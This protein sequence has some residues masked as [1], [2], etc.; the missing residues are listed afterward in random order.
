MGQLIK[1][2]IGQ[3]LISQESYDNKQTKLL[4]LSFEGLVSFIAILTPD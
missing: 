3:E 4:F 1:T 2:P